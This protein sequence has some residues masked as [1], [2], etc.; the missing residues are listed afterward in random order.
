MAKLQPDI[1]Y[2]SPALES[3]HR[4]SQPIAHSTQSRQPG[5]NLKATNR[6]PSHFH[7]GLLVARLHFLR[8][9]FTR[10]PSN[11]NLRPRRNYIH[12]CLGVGKKGGVT[13]SFSRI[14]SPARAIRHCLESQF[15]RLVRRAMLPRGFRD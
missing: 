13:P 6:S 1:V 2:S 9:S 5:V 10:S 8:R 3:R 11:L 12:P 14:P 15:A 7:L 4:Q